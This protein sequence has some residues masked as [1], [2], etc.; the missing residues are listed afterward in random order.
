MNLASVVLP[1][2]TRLTFST[3][4]L[5]DVFS[6][7]QRLDDCLEVGHQQSGWHSLAGHV[8]DAEPQPAGAEFEDIKIVASDD[9]RRPPTARNL[10]TGHLRNFLGHERLL[11][12]PGLLILLSLF[13]KTDSWRFNAELLGVLR[14]EPRPIELHRLTSNDAADGSSAEKAI[15]NIETNVPPGSTHGDEAAIDIVPEREARAAAERLELPPEVAATP[16]VLEQARRLGPL[17][18]G[19]G[20]LRRRRPD[21]RELHRGSNRTQAPIGFKGSPL[22]QMRRVGKRLPDFFRRV[23][24]FSHENERPLLAVLSYLRPPGRTRCVLLAIG[25]LLLLTVNSVPVG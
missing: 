5:G 6:A 3:T 2:I 13:A 9:A 4:S 1:D 10:Q 17:H 21:Q 15:H 14:V 7:S 23:A 12:F 11:D 19:L 20:D 16:V 24:Q 18:G 25:H 22:A 8:G